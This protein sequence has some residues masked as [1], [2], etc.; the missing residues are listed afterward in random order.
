MWSRGVHEIWR[1]ALFRINPTF[2]KPCLMGLLGILTLFWLWP[3]ALIIYLIDRQMTGEPV[4][5]TT[6]NR[7]L[8]WTW[9]GIRKLK[10]LLASRRLTKI[11]SS[12]HGYVERE[13][14]VREH[15]GTTAPFELLPGASQSVLRTIPRP[16][17]LDKHRKTKGKVMW[18]RQKISS[19]FKKKYSLVVD[20]L[21]AIQPRL[22][23]GN[24]LSH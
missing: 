2:E 14:I 8:Y 16:A 22:H 10:K 12:M 24:Q 1:V 20:Q 4:S 9:R 21:E 17:R 13:R 5:C 7:H 3:W 11:L 19:E 6:R 23:R 15:M 18:T